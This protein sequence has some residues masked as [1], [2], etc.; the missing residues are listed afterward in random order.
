MLRVLWVQT[1][2]DEAPETLCKLGCPLLRTTDALHVWA[3]QVMGMELWLQ[4]QDSLDLS[5]S[6]A[7]CSW[8]TSG[9]LLTWQSP[10]FLIG[11]MGNVRPI[12]LSFPRA[13]QGLA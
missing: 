3:E 12:P 9:M 10:R 2:W 4:V 5:P 1:R 7:T 13:A 11:K 8:V 6:S